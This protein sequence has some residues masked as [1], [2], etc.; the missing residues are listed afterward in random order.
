MLA[1]RA[2]GSA[3][4]PN[5]SSKKNDPSTLKDHSPND[6]SLSD[7][8]PNEDSPN[9]ETVDCGTN[10]SDSGGIRG[11]ILR[12]S[13]YDCIVVSFENNENEKQKPCSRTCISEM[14]VS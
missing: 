1:A 10:N 7:R 2:P 9:V 12:V 13:I 14:V 11:P 4:K 5:V 6:D 3:R 8:D